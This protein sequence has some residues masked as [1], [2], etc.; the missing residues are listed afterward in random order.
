MPRHRKLGDAALPYSPN[1]AS[2][3]DAADGHPLL[4][5][6]SSAARMEFFISLL[7]GDLAPPLRADRPDR[8]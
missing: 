3:A 4:R 8:F 6:A 1:T 7:V 2:R 5:M